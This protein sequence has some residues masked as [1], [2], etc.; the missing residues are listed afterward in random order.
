MAHALLI[1]LTLALLVGAILDVRENRIPNRLIAL[2]LPLALLAAAAQF[3]MAALPGALGAGLIAFSL[4]FVAFAVGA[5]GGGDAKF[6]VVGAVAVGM[7]QLV[8]FLLAFG[9]LGGALAVYTIARNRLGIEATVMTLDLVKNFGTLGRSGHRARLTDEGRITI[10]YGVAI[11][12]GALLT[13]F[14]NYPEWLLS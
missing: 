10:P 7:E 1:P 5:I 13:L 2:A 4:G 3:G 9:V 11:A 8:P 14:T 12:G 6:L